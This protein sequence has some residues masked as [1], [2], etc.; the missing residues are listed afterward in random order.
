MLE[1][2]RRKIEEQTGTI[3]QIE[4][5][6]DY[7]DHD[8]ESFMEGKDLSPFRRNM[9]RRCFIASCIVDEKLKELKKVSDELFD[10]INKL[11]QDDNENPA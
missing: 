11:L 4:T 5:L 9:G 2:M 1:Q 3:E 8:I 6:C 7:L 10:I